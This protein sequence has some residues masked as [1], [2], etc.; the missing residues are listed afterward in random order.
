M[1][2]IATSGY[3]AARLLAA[4]LLI[5]IFA[6]VAYFV[7]LYSNL[8]PDSIGAFGSTLGVAVLLSGTLVVSRVAHDE[9]WSE[10]AGTAIGLA[11]AYFL[12]TWVLFGDPSVSP[13]DRPHV[14]WFGV[15]VVAFMPAVVLMP[16]SKW[17]WSSFRNRMSVSAG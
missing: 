12:I 15:C 8:N 13:D 5:P 2:Q 14:V 9:G 1:A 11:L 16:L 4:A 3:R 7:A 10:R 6:V 17:A